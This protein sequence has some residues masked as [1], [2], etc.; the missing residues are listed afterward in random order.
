VE[1][2]GVRVTADL[3]ENRKLG[4]VGNCLR[5]LLCIYHGYSLCLGGV[6]GGS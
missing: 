4:K 6:G 3:W 2:K 5:G 1:I